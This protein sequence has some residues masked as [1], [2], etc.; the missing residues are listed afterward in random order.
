[1]TRFLTL[2]ELLGWA[3]FFTL[4]VSR[5]GPTMRQCKL[6]RFV[7][8]TPELLDAYFADTPEAE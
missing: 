3:S 6:R 8:L 1:M 5:G 2:A 4:S 7:P